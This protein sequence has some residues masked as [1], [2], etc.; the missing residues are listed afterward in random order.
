MSGKGGGGEVFETVTPVSK[1]LLLCV[2]ISSGF[3]RREGANPKVYGQ[4]IIWPNF[5]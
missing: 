1:F 2:K 4:P 3:P 5:A